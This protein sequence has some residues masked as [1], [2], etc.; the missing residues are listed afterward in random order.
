MKEAGM[1]EGKG[2]REV[3]QK[4]RHSQKTK[5]ALRPVKNNCVSNTISEPQCYSSDKINPRIRP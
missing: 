4:M 5:A 3:Q 2:E 1:H